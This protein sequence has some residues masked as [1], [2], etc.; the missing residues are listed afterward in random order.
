MG[1]QGAKERED[2][3][4]NLFIIL[5]TRKLQN[6]KNGLIVGTPGDDGGSGL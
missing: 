4:R 5:Y 1:W 6:Y 3:L 2:V